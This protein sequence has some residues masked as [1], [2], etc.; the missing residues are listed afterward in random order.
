MK[1]RDGK[2]EVRRSTSLQKLFHK[3]VNLAYK[4]ANYSDC[5]LLLEDGLDCLSTQLEDKLNAS[6]TTL[7]KPRNDQ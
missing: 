4:V 2:P 5:C 3:F 7:N 1:K 6:T